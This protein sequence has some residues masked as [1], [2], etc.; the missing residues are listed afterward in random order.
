M[1]HKLSF[2]QLHLS[3]EISHSDVA[4]LQLLA[5]GIQLYLFV[6]KIG[7]LLGKGV[8]SRSVCFTLADGSVT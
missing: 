7:L 3:F 6:L 5:C 8:R 4:G 1:C 2:Q